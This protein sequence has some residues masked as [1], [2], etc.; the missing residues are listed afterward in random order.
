MLPVLPVHDIAAALTYYTDV[1]GF[2]EVFR[3][4]GPD[5]TFVN[6]QVAF[7]GSELMFNLNPSMADKQG[8]GVYFW[9]RVDD[10]DIDAYYTA[11]QGNNVTVTEEIK[12][13]FWG[14]RSFSI[15]DMNGYNLAFNKAL[16]KD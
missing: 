6:A 9:I 11:L 1:L 16:P 8:G 12:D 4:P 13:Q 3:M 15:Q 7:H 5:G 10:L 2:D 14:D